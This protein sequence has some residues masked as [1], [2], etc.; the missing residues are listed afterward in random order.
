VLLRLFLGV[1][2]RGGVGF[3]GWE[4]EGYGEI[5]HIF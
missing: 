5:I 4:I 2:R 1:W 3:G